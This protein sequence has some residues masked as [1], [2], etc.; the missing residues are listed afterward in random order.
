MLDDSL[1]RQDALGEAVTACGGRVVCARDLGPALRLWSRAATL[2]AL[3]QRLADAA[4]DGEA[5]IVFAGSGDFHHVTPLLIERATALAD[6]PV[7]VV[8]FDN[9]PDWARFAPGQHCGSWVSRAARLEGVHQIVTIGVTSRDVGARRAGAGD[10]ALVAEERLELFAWSLPDH[11]SELTVAGR[12]WPTI[13][14]L[15]ETAFVAHLDAVVRTRGV[16]VTIDKDVLRGQD[17]VTNWD[18]GEASL[19][20]VE[21]CVRRIARGRR[22]VGADVVGDWS[23]PAY[24]W[25]PASWLKRGEAF[26]DQPRRPPAPAAANVVNQ[27]ANLRLLDLFTRAAA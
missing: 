27:A 17:A 22:L 10:L 24:G 20:F 26:L 11:Q 21:S 5:E 23:P 2:D 19:D 1:E 18:Q 16:Y 25:G 12:S 3:R 13:T 14:A 6:E 8:H 9:H 15:G 4:T 7:T